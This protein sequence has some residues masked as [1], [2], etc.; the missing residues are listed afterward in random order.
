MNIEE[1]R[2]RA[3]LALGLVTQTNGI[4]QRLGKT[5]H[6]TKLDYQALP[7]ADQIALTDRMAGMIKANPAEFTPQQVAVATSRVNSTY[8]NAP[9]QLT[10][11]INVTSEL[12]RSGELQDAMFAGAKKYTT[13]INQIALTLGALGATVFLI[14]SFNKGSR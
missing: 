4:Y 6:G 13:A 5:W 14:H 2:Q 10:S 1:L 3:A 7:A 9:L 11:Y 8:Y 12:I